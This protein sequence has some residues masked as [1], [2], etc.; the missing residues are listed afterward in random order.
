LGPEAGEDPAREPSS[1]PGSEPPASE[2]PDSVPKVAE[3]WDDT[4]P[5]KSAPKVPPPMHSMIAG[6]VLGAAIGDAM[7]HP[8]EFISSM[9]RIRERYG[10]EGVTTFELF[11]ERDG[12]RF[13]PYTDDTQMAEVV[14]RTLLD[15]HS[16]LDEA[17]R[18]MAR[19]V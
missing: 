6:A 17:M 16:D 11:W 15:G 14:L 2:P 3:A 1:S 19:G 18:R 9:E 10:P 13:A 7:G 8:T 12:K 4:P 5:A